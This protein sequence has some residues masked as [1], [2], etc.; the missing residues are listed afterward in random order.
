MHLLSRYPIWRK[1]QEL[2]IRLII[3]IFSKRIK[4]FEERKILF[5]KTVLNNHHHNIFKHLTKI[6]KV[7][8]YS[9]VLTSK[10]FLGL[11]NPFAFESYLHKNYSL[12]ISS[13]YIYIYIIYKNTKRESE[14]G[15]RIPK[16]PS[17][18][19][20]NLPRGRLNAGNTEIIGNI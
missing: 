19:N 18:E 10:T 1:A 16:S 4:D 2:S 17:I 11:K 20:F 12:T 8:Q 15:S 6:S 14:I 7:I 13:I 5:I 3:L 9:L